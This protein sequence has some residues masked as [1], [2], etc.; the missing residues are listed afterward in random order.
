MFEAITQGLEGFADLPTELQLPFVAA[1]AG[2]VGSFVNVCI[3]RIPRGESVIFPRS[4]CPSCNALLGPPDLVPVLSYVVLRG[5]CRHCGVPFSPRYMLVELVLILLWSA[6][7]FWLGLSWQF[8]AAALVATAAVAGTGI[9]LMVRSIRRQRAGFTFISILLAMTL[10]V[11]FIGPFLD[12]VR[13]GFMGAAKNREYL[14]AY[15]LLRE[16]L[17]ELRM[18]PVRQLRSDWEVYVHGQRLT[19]NIF[20]D[21]FGPL[22]RWG[23]NEKVFYSSFSDVLTERTQFPDSVQAKFDRNWKRYYGF[24]YALY[25]KEYGVFKRVTKVQDLSDP[26][27]PNMVLQKATVTVTINSQLTKNRSLEVSVILSDRGP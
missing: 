6:A 12:I 16:K 4:H 7:L 13:T 26:T 10:F 19:D 8:F 18:I 15:N 20:L 2:L 17:E 14:L 24:P 1:F 25:P 27:V 3:W 11:I 9:L 5:R 23:Q 21:E 22:S